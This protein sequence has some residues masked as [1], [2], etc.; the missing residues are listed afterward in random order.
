[1]AA[2]WGPFLFVALSLLLYLA[3][4]NPVRLLILA[5]SLNGLI[6]PLSLGVVL[7]AAR[8]R[9]L[10]GEYRH[11]PA[12]AAAGWAAFVVALLASALALFEFRR[13]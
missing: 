5:G 10:M 12:L 1:V 2:R 13:L 4:G 3:V 9:D 8:R 6:L 7:L 11:P